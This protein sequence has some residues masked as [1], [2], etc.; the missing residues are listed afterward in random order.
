MGLTLA[1]ELAQ[2]GSSDSIGQAIGIRPIKA[3]CSVN[4]ILKNRDAA[5]N[6]DIST[7]YVT[8]CPAC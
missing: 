7:S 8:A 3:N 6:Q 2:H 1:L 4:D 5:V